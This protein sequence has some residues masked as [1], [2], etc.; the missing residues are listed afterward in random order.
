[1]ARRAVAPKSGVDVR[2]HLDTP[3]RPEH[4]EGLADRETF[5][6]APEAMMALVRPCVRGELHEERFAGVEPMVT[7]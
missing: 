4:L 6:C 7:S 5:L 2:F 1:M 3:F